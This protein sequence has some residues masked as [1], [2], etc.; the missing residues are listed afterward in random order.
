MY[1]SPW[2]CRIIISTMFIINTDIA[3][4]YNVFIAVQTTHRPEAKG[5]DDATDSRRRK[6]FVD[7]A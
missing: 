6:Q 4:L 3:I 2:F 7:A 5:G 1:I